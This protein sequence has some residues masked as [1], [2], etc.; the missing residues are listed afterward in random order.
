MLFSQKDDSEDVS[1][2]RTPHE[3]DAGELRLGRN[4]AGNPQGPNGNGEPN[5]EVPEERNGEHNGNGR[6]DQNGNHNNNNSEGREEHN[7]DNNGDDYIQQILDDVDMSAAD[8][9]PQQPSEEELSVDNWC[10]K[11]AKEE[12]ARRK[13]EKDNILHRILNRGVS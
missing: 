5:Q 10:R 12:G 1:R 13:A 9:P 2:P 3:R 11:S 4:G 8:N 7:T 6:E